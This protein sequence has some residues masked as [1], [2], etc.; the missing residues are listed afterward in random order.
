LR[1]RKAII[2]RVFAPINFFRIFNSFPATTLKNY[3]CKIFHFNLKSEKSIIFQGYSQ[4]CEQTFALRSELF[5][6]RLKWLNWFAFLQFR[7][8]HE[9]L[10][11]YASKDTSSSQYFTAGSNH[12]NTLSYKNKRKENSSGIF[13]CKSVNFNESS[14]W[15]KSNCIWWIKIFRVDFF[16]LTWEKKF[17]SKKTFDLPQKSHGFSINSKAT[18]IINIQFIKLLQ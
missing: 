8:T 6:Q 12:S 7:K 16:F 3:S 17:L 10:K 11:V 13:Y 9:E 18:F 5:L 15:I 2:S 1:K 14:K 4:N